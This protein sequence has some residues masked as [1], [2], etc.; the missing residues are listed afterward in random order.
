MRRNPP[1]TG[2]ACQC[3][4]SAYQVSRVR[5]VTSSYRHTVLVCF[6]H[7]P[8]GGAGVN[9]WWLP[10]KLYT[11]AELYN[12]YTLALPAGALS[13]RIRSDRYGL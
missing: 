1:Y 6:D 7:R 13:V 11:P 9:F 2:T 4:G 3:I 8:P 10:P 5:L 12:F